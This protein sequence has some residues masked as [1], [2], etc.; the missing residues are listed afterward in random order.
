MIKLKNMI[1]EVGYEKIFSPQTMASLKGKSGESL[2]QMIG[3]KDFRQAVIRTMHLLPEISRIESEY[4]DELEPLAVQMVKDAYPII[5]Y[6]GIEIDAKITSMDEIHELIDKKEEEKPK[7]KSKELI[8]N[9]P[10]EDIPDDKKRRIINGITQGASIRGA[11]WFLI[12]REYLDQLDPTL[13]EKYKE[14]MNLSLGVYDDEQFIA[15]LLAMLAMNTK[16]AGGASM[17][18]VEKSLDDDEEDEENEKSEP[19]LKIIAR[20]LNFPMLVYEIVKGLYEIISLQGFGANKEKNQQVVKRIDKLKNEPDD[21]R[22]GKF[23][24]DAIN[25]LYQNSH[26]DDPRIRELLFTEIYKLSDDD[27]FPFIENVLNN[28]LTPSQKRWVDNV[29]RD[30]EKDLKNDDSDEFLY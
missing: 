18:E 26:Y 9:N 10:L 23:I 21:L 27:F 14:I 24:Y 20:A 7:I 1:K 30:I 3:N 25:E 4:I 11:F 16:T 8:N 22:Y 6:A 12:F 17:V 29:M 15:A 2:R 5:D 28:K 13:V 19:T